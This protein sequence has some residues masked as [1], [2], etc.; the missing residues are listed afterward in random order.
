MYNG[1]SG[2]FC[3]KLTDDTEEDM[4]KQNADSSKPE[5]IAPDGEKELGL[6]H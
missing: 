1:R 5:K 2:I 3:L 4:N 6:E